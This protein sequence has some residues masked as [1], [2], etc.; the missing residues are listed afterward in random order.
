[1]AAKTFLSLPYEIINHIFKNY[2]SFDDILNSSLSLLYTRYHEFII[3]SYIGPAL[4]TFSKLDLQLR[5]FLYEEGWTVDCKNSE[6]IFTLW[7]KYKPYTSRGN[8]FTQN[9]ST[10]ILL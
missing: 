3:V 4:D 8:N 9:I 6:L 1:M 10:N 5:K 7:N 2:L